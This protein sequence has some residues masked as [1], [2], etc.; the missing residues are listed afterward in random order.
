MPFGKDAYN[1]D[2]KVHTELE[3][4]CEV[5]SIA[6]GLGTLGGATDEG[7]VAAQALGIRENAASEISIGYA[8]DGTGCT[9]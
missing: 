2:A 7:L 8:R 5:I 6:G 4:S 9:M 1:F 3:S